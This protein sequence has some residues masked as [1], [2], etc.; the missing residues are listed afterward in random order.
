MQQLADPGRSAERPTEVRATAFT[1]RGRDELAGRVP[2]GVTT[3]AKP[4]PAR[5]LRASW[6][7]WELPPVEW[8][9]GRIDVFHG[10][11]FVLPPTQHAR[12]VVTMHDLSSLRYPETVTADSLR[13]Q[14]LVPRSIR[15][16]AVVCALS[17]AAADDIAAEYGVE[18][19]ATQVTSPGVDE[20]W[21]HAEPPDDVTRTRLGLPDRCMLAVSTLE[22]RKKLPLL[23][24][25][26]RQCRMS[27]AR[28]HRAGWLGARQSLP[29]DTL[30]QRMARPRRD[31][32]RLLGNSCCTRPAELDCAFEAICENCSFFA[33]GI[34]FGP[35]LQ[36]HHNDASARTR[37]APADL[38]PA[39]RRTEPDRVMTSGQMTHPD[40]LPVPSIDEVSELVTREAID[41][42]AKLRTPTGSAT[43]HDLVGVGDQPVDQLGVGDVA[44]TSSTRSRAGSG[45]ASS[46]A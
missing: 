27:P 43:L 30:G 26:Y 41:Q 6:A 12:G 19:A 36:L 35:I 24:A 28:A 20:S 18:R 45:L 46:P 39:P 38:R 23:V 11:N 4:V 10:T 8:L 9:C 32:F 17:N 15:R 21:F 3:R 34:E 13:Y 22:P 16:P 7:R 31:H 5:L 29:A 14:Q 1:L 25:A 42:I 44:L 40:E 33:T 37:P 2:S